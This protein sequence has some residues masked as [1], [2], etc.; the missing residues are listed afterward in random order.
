MPF[1]PEAEEEDDRSSSDQFHQT[2]QQY[3]HENVSINTPPTQTNDRG[4]R[5]FEAFD[6]IN[7]CLINE[8]YS[9]GDHQSLVAPQNNIPGFEQQLHMNFDGDTWQSLIL[10]VCVC[11]FSSSN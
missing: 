1:P 5:G 6:N 11:V 4:D 9:Y 7:M 10:Q 8:H 3:H 2:F